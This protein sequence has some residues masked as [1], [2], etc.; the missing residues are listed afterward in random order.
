MRN[1]N[2]QM[3]ARDDEVMKAYMDYKKREAEASAQVER[4]QAENSE[5]KAKLEKSLSEQGLEKVKKE[6]REEA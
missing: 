3:E 6:A 1:L 5:I 4:L 2:E